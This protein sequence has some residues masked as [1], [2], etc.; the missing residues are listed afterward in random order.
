VT[1]YV[2]VHGACCGSWIWKRVRDRLAAAGHR[3]FTPTLTGLG[4]RS[5]L[6]DRR[7][8]V[9]THIDDVANLLVWEELRDVVLVGH[10]YAGFVVRHVADRMPERLRSLVYLDAF[11]PENGKRIQDYVP[12]IKFRE[13]AASHGEGWKVP[14]I[15]AAAFGVNA[16]DIAWVDRQATM[17][18]LSTLETPARLT[19]A[20]DEVGNIGI[21]PGP[22]AS[23][24]PVP[25]VLSGGG[26]ARLVAGRSAQRPRR[27]ARHAGRADRT[28]VA[29]T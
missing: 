3:V 17:H 11:V 7:L 19:G 29:R 25:A 26:G 15:P 6:L 1:V 18:P 12:N 28:A 10:S 16:A 13:I 27:D 24:Q 9:E 8:G 21:H 14:P 5:H 2:L 4:E 20:C 22:R 23:R